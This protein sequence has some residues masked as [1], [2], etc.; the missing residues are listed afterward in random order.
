LRGANY[1]GAKR[2]GHTGY[3]YAHDY[4]DHFVAQAYIPTSAVYYEP[5]NQGY[6]DTLKQR[7]AQWDQLRGEAEDRHRTT[8][9]GRQTGEEGKEANVQR[10]M[11]K[12]NGRRKASDGN[13]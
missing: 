9:G 4:K 5:T 6:E 11:K 1:K 3:Q 7:L 10:P 2:L 13:S 12:E 8:D